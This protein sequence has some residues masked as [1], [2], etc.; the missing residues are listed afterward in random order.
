[1][2]AAA[3]QGDTP[4]LQ[5]FLSGNADERLVDLLAFA[6]ATEAGGGAAEPFRAK[7]AAALGDHAARTMHNRIEEIRR[8]AMAEQLRGLRRPLGFGRT[9]V[10]NLVTLLIAAAAGAWLYGQPALLARIL[11]WFAA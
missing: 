4:R 10:A 9:V 3:P 2:T 8:D 5:H 7:A 1:M 6:M 11:G